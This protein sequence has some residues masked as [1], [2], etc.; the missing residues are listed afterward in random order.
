MYKIYINDT[1]IFLMNTQDNR[2]LLPSS[3]NILIAKYLGKPKYLLTYI[4]MLEKSKKFDA[5]VLHSENYEKLVEDFKGLYKIIEAAG[6]V[7]F[8]DKNEI[9]MIYRLQIWDLPKGKI[10]D[11]ETPEATAV[12]EVEE[13]TGINN[14]QIGPLITKTYHT[15]KNG[16][17]K[18][19]LKRTYWYRMETKDQ[20]LIPQAEE[21]IEIAEWIL[22]EK[23]LS[24]K[25]KAYRSIMEVLSCAQ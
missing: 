1:P 4:D 13:E 10:D 17:R 14:I 23:F 3:E 18:R 12:R 9:L 20:K 24:E 11:G 19:I 21:N 8:N 16:K 2:E 5:V 6:G 22:L 7:V 15:Y 25:R